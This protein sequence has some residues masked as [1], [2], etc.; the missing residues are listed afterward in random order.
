MLQK[1]LTVLLSFVTL[2]LSVGK[3]VNRV[4]APRDNENFVPVIRFVVASDT[5]IKAIGDVRTQR[6]QKIL[7]LAY[8]D[9]K[10]DAAYKKLDAALFVG[11]LTNQGRRSQFLGFCGAVSSVLQ[12]ETKCLAVVAKSHD[13][14]TLG[15]QS[16]A[17]FEELTGQDS[18]FHVVLNG[19]HF[20]GLSASK[21][22]LHHYSEDQRE[23]LREQIDEAVRDDPQ[24]P[25]F[26]M[27]HEHVSDTVYGSYDID[28]WGIDYFKDI[29]CD[30]PQIVHFSGHSHYPIN[31]PRSIWQGAF[32][33]VGTG[34]VYYAELTVDG[35]SRV[36]PENYETIAQCWIVEADAK[37]RV[38]LRGF[39]ALSGKLLCSYTLHDL[40]NA[41]ARQYTPDVLQKAASAPAFPKNAD[42][43]VKKIGSKY[44]FTAP[45][46][47]STDGQIVFLYRLTVCNQ[48]G[49][50][51]HT[52]TL[53]NDY[54]I[55]DCYETVR[56][57]ARAKSGCTVSIV[58]ENAY[59]MQ[60]EPLTA[61]IP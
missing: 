10:Q 42:V 17:L 61:I 6:I 45:A 41:D 28:G 52:Q 33:A 37:N 40:A 36:H 13:G 30:Y 14:N 44:S 51:I 50:E 19:F 53:V 22:P 26:V 5:H 20:I 29:F 27:H 18:D 47:Q 49:K 54:W 15:K 60:S 12:S 46:A 4:T 9:A 23:W 57:T 34:A 8:S 43:S 55:A 32:T 48:N 1:I 24:K 16:L 35:K 56:F 39:D 2:V 58:A 3:P 59:G 21:T 31:D 25:V 11:D 7:S 38:R